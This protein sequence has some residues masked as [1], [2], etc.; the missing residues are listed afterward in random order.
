MMLKKATSADI[1]ARNFKVSPFGDIFAAVFF[2]LPR[3]TRTLR[4][5]GKFLF[6]SI[7]IDLLYMIYQLSSVTLANLR[8]FNS[9]RSNPRMGNIFGVLAY[10]G[11]QDIG[12]ADQSFL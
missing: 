2:R 4:W 9:N 11:R 10:G 6:V 7:T 1:A 12:S 5:G 8:G 3:G